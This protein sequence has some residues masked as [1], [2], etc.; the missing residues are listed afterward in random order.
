[1]STPIQHDA[2]D[3]KSLQY[4][5]PRKLRDSVNDPPSMQP[6][7]DASG[8]TVPQPSEPWR[9]RYDNAFLADALPEALR[10]LVEVE[11]Q[12]RPAG[13][14]RR[15]TFAILA[16]FGACAGIAAGMVFL[17]P[18]KFAEWRDWAL[19]PKKTEISLAERLQAANVALN[20]VTRNVVAPTLV[21]TDGSG[22]INAPL[23]LGI[24]VTNYTPGATVYLS[25]L[26]AGAAMSTG[27]AAGEGGW[28]IAVDDLPNTLVIPPRGYVGPMSIVAELR[29]GNRQAIVRSPVR[30]TWKQAAADTSKALAPAANASG[31]NGAEV[32][33]PP[34]QMDPTEAAALLKRAEELISS[35]DLPAA[36]LLLQRVAESHN[37]LAAFELGATYDPIVIKKLGS[38]SAVPDLALAKTWYQRAR[39]W[40]SSDA[41]EHLEALASINR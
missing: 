36:R 22:D 1:M 12:S 28:R 5:A 30:Y 16:T 7:A 37:A 33:V 18:T 23:P 39:D 29:G 13:F 26:L 41:S 6:L 38:I 2:L 11:Y 4:Y 34:R 25:G 3:P 40:G 8:A 14:P 19:P 35:G 24:A 15:R 20:E 10:R 27:A 32:P 17:D 31:A 21:V 9:P